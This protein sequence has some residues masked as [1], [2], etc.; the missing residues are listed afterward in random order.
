MNYLQVSADIW[1]QTVGR[2]SDLYTYLTE[3]VCFLIVLFI[4]SRGNQFNVLFYNG[5]VLFY[6]HDHLQ[7]FFDIAKDGKKLLQA[8]YSEFQIQ[9]YLC[10][11]RAVGL[12]NNFSTGTLWRFF[13]VWDSYS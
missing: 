7:S 3:E 6:F 10:G 8:V 11:F 9:S 12:T 5:G 13:G 1:L 2:I 4:P